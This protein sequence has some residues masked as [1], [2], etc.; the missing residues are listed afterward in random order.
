M[1]TVSFTPT[2]QRCITLGH[3]YQIVSYDRDGNPSRTSPED[4]VRLM[5]MMCGTSMTRVATTE[6]TAEIEKME[7]LL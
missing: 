7:T 2:L 3:D 1:R 5:C 6:E 4:H